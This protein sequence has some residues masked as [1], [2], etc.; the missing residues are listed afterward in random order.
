MLNNPILKCYAEQDIEWIQ[1]Y[2]SLDRTKVITELN[3]SDV[4]AI[5]AVQRKVGNSF[6]RVWSAKFLSG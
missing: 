4:E 5:Q 2:V 1:S 3:A 6:D